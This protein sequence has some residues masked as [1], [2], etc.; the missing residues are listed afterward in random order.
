MKIAIDCDGVLYE[1]EK[2]ARYMLREIRGCGGLFHASDN[3]D[4]IMNSVPE[5]DWRWLW[6]EGV[7]LGLFRH[8][9]LVQGS[10][11]GVRA[12]RD[13][14]HELY[15][16]THRP[17]SAV[18][19]TTAWLELHF[20]SEDPYPWSGLHILS[21]QESKTMVDA[22]LLIDDKPENISEWQASGREGILFSRPWNR[23][24]RRATWIANGW[25]HAV[26]LVA[27]AE[28]KTL[29][30]HPAE[31]ADMRRSLADA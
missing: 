29:L 6:T 5:E 14:G 12:L 27:L 19:D 15:L 7:R 1:W 11:I 4:T 13:A 20:G 2:T 24:Y 30:F 23:D 18:R 9:H 28:P 26:S 17:K 3:W 31:V 16:V 8:G 21:N 10:I 25:D 22:D